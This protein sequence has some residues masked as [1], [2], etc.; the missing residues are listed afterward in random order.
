MVL[1]SCIHK[2]PQKLQEVQDE[3]TSIHECR[4]EVSHSFLESGFDVFFKRKA[5]HFDSVSL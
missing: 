2:V 5:V 4:P 3:D 1:S